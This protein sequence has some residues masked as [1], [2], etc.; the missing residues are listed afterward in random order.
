MDA[1]E[2]GIAAE[3]LKDL[4]IS[5]V[6]LLTNNPEKIVGL[7]QHG[8]IVERV[9]LQTETPDATKAYLAVKKQKMGHLLEVE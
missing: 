7:Q 1:R 9:P 6:R 3:M 5:A 8:I 4:G 2:Y